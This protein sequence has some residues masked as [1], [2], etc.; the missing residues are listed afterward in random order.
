MV[1]F[2]NEDDR[3]IDWSN[4]V[5]FIYFVTS[6]QEEAQKIGEELISSKLAACINM[7]PNMN[8]IYTWKGKVE[9]AKE[10]VCIA[11]T[12]NENIITAVDMIERMHSY[13]V[14]A[15]LVLPVLGGN[16]KFMNHVRNQVKESD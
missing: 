8:S 9:R 14:P 12:I 6:D 16:L 15:I 4:D 11:K 13:D 7:I 2:Q 10:C 5:R 3:V 1:Q